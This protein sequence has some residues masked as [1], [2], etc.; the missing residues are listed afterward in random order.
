MRRLLRRFRD[1]VLR[2]LSQRRPA[3]A[4]AGVAYRE[5][6]RAARPLSREHPVEREWLV[7]RRGAR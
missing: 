7:P 5:R 1:R 2:A 3:S 6:R 4:P